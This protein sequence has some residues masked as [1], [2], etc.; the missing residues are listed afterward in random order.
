MAKIVVLGLDGFN[1]ELVKQWS[2]ELPNLMKMQK[3]GI[4]GS[5]KCIPPLTIPQVW[6]CA[7]CGRN[8]GAYGFWDFTYRDEFSYSET[9]VVNPEITRRV[10]LLQTVLPKM[11]QRVGIINVPVTWPP[12]KIPAGYAISGFM[13]P[14]LD[15]PFTYP[16]S[17]KEKVYKLVWEY[18]IDVTEAEVGC[19]IDKGRV[20]KNI[21]DMDSQRFL[22]TRYFIN[23]KKCDYV[24]TVVMGSECM[25]NLFYRCFDSKGKQYD[26]DPHYKG[27]LH[28]YYVWIDKNVGELRESLP[29][30]VVLFIHSG[31]GIQKLEGRINLNEWLI[32]EGYMSLLEY[33]MKLTSSKDVKVDWS[34][35]KC[36]SSGYTGKLYLNMKGREPQGI[37]EA[38]DYDKLLDELAAKLK[39][40]PDKL[41]SHLNTQVWKRDEVCFGPYA[42][43]GPDLFVSF[44]E[45]RL[46]T[47]ELLGRG[48][49][50]IYSFD[51][52]K[53]SY[54]A[55]RGLY[56]YFVIAGSGI[57]EQG[58][59][60]E[61]SLLNVAPTV[62]DV[63][64]LPIP[65]NMERPSILSMVKKGGTTY[66][67]KAE[68]AVRSRL[69]SLGY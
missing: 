13:T 7:Q 21:Y 49:E 14:N 68:R 15:R 55:V 46:G 3:E 12:P 29:K 17:L 20:L 60:K 45:G 1:P 54:D 53:G 63:L 58:E 41:G 64:G 6:T 22:L 8:P 23:E 62:L 19:E 37:V 42:K 11:G 25:L 69:E 4:W 52:A 30:S 66:P 34:K 38:K 32:K 43:Y 67:K 26:P 24:M 48:R 59:L 27:A 28:D 2:D 33:P 65:K 35:T 40:I 56:G 44:D 10:D 39:D 36:W 5:L 57:P 18:I 47:S 51:T 50:K 9:K 61:V 31:Y 16:D